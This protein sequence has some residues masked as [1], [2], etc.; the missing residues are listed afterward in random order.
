MKYLDHVYSNK[1]VKFAE[2][3]S[4]EEKCSAYQRKIEETLK[5]EYQDKVYF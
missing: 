3:L 4:F 1:E 5:K 2:N